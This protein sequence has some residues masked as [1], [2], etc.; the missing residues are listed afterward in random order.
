MRDPLK[1]LLVFFI[2]CL[3]RFVG[4]AEIDLFKECEVSG[5][6]TLFDEELNKWVETDSRDAKIRS[7]PASTFKILNAL[8]ALDRNITTQNETFEWDRVK[9]EVEAWNADTNLETAFR[10]STVWVFELLAKRFGTSEYLPI[11]KQIKYGNNEITKGLRGNFWVY[12]KFGVSP[13]E[14]IDLL[15]ALYKNKLPFSRSSMEAVKTFMKDRNDSNVFGK[16]GW[17]SEGGRHVGWWVGWQIRK[18]KP[19]F[20]A[21]RIWK[22][23]TAPLGDFAACRKTITTTYLNLFSNR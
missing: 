8:I 7:L 14:Q 3:G 2:V 10:N 1:F 23:K 22:S 9:R 21:T 17:T 18:K 16:T 19:I 4:A 6:V 15:S 13:R 12:G 11:L 20:F 5:S